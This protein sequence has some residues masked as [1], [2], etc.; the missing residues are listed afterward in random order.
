MAERYLN[1][2]RRADGGDVPGPGIVVPY[3]T[4]IPG[5][6]VNLF[7]FLGTDIDRIIT[8][9]EKNVDDTVTSMEK[10]GDGPDFSSCVEDVLGIHPFMET[11]DNLAFFFN[12][13]VLSYI[14]ECY[15]SYADVLRLAGSICISPFPD[16]AVM[17][18]LLSCNGS[19]DEDGT[20]SLYELESLRKSVKWLMEVVFD[21]T[22]DSVKA[23][24]QARRET[25]Y[26][27][28]GPCVF[29][30]LPDFG[31]RGSFSTG[32]CDGGRLFRAK[33]DSDEEYRYRVAEWAKSVFGDGENP[34]A[35]AGLPLFPDDACEAVRIVYEVDGLEDLIGLEIRQMFLEGIR[36]KRCGCC[37]RYYVW[38]E[39]VPGYCVIPDARTK[40]VS[41]TCRARFLKDI[42]ASM[43]LKAYKTHNQRLNRG[44]CS[45]EEMDR[46][47]EEAREARDRAVVSAITMEEY[48]DILKR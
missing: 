27:W 38:H 18:S 33:A 46:W 25:F 7:R 47:K 12:N 3:D 30:R 34:P 39:G 29:P 26:E 24:G 17:A 9:I 21:D 45:R 44:S 16:R 10:G 42:A 19:A 22:F 48:A 15:G 36:V 28:A 37:G 4:M 43:Y 32:L 20:Y 13:T 6:H 1:L 8:D 31:F 40:D 2:R 14:G 35:G 11:G 23:L 5:D 41:G